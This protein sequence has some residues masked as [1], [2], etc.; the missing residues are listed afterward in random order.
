MSQFCREDLE[1]WLE[2]WA[3]WVSGGDG[4]MSSLGRL[5]NV[6]TGGDGGGGLV[7]YEDQERTEFAVIQL[8][9][10]DEMAARVVRIEFGVRPAGVSVTQCRKRIGRAQA[11]GIS[12]ATYRRKLLKAEQMISDYLVETNPT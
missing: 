2:R 11:L 8:A 5:A 4:L 1:Q 3:K 6:R 10:A 9:H 12:Y 7:V